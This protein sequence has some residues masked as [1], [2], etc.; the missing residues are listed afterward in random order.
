MAIYG[1]SSARR[2][3]VDAQNAALAE[4][5]DSQ[6]KEVCDAVDDNE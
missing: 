2:I 1:S 6:A 3:V 4:A 5:V